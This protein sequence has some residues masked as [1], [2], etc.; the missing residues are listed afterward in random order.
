MAHVLGAKFGLSHGR[1]NGVLLP[2]V[3]EYNA[4][5]PSKFAA[6]PNYEYYVA[7]EKY[8]QIARYLGLPS[9]TVEEGVHSLV[10]AIRNLMQQLDIPLT[11]AD[12]GIPK[13]EFEAAVPE[14]LRSF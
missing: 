1:A 14:I 12:C 13:A 8:Q 5:Y 11:I 3:I 4:S 9:Q 7:P 6:F 2:Y 10:G